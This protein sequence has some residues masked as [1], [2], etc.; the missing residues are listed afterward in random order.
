MISNSNEFTI[1][2]LSNAS[3]NVFNQNTREAFRNQLSQPIH[4]QGECQLALTSLCFP[5]NINNV[6]SGEIVVYKKSTTD[7]DESSNRSGQLR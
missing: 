3:M 1:D 4:L 7:A 5:S 2:S 6:N